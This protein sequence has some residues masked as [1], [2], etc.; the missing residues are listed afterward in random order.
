MSKMKII[1]S[2]TFMT[3]FLSFSFIWLEGFPGWSK[4][5]QTVA[6]HYDTQVLNQVKP[7]SSADSIDNNNSKPSPASP[8][9]VSE[10]SA[11]KDY[12]DQSTLSQPKDNPPEEKIS[13]PEQSDPPLSEPDLGKQEPEMWPEE[14]QVPAESS[15]SSIEP[16]I[17]S[18]PV[19][20]SE[21]N[22]NI[23]IAGT[24]KDELS[25]SPQ[26]GPPDTPV[27]PY[28]DELGNP[29]T[30]PGLAMR[31]RKFIPEKGKVAYL[32]FDDGPYPSSTSKILEIL[33]EENVKAT[34]F[35]IGK[36]V[37][38]YPDLLKAEYE[39]GHGIGNH[40]YSHNMK[41]IYKT[42]KDFLADVKKAEEIIYQTIGIRPQLIR[43]PGGTIGHFNI[44]YFNAIDAEGYLMEDWNVDPGDSKAQQV[45]K[46]QL[47]QLVEQQIQ[48]KTRVVVL[49]H[50]LVG[51]DTTIDALPEIIRMLRKQGFSFEVL[52]PNVMPII[53]SGGLMKN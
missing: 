51:K 6:R 40:T 21:L 18:E 37:E 28:Y 25:P 5:T 36:Q 33:A 48:G 27:H 42:P 32:T 16:P 50:D 2:I 41:E 13:Q 34:F 17:K 38:L 22:P 35:A 7:T 11:Q 49:L 12:P 45:P 23:T 31:Q 44:S 10:I 30:A 26:P 3:C 24:V 4:A 43:A 14:S 52:S 53:F 8:A 39:Q 19:S 1:G 47:V 15:G 29:P 9:L 46:N 20:E